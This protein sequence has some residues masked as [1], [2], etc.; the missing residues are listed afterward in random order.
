MPP[1]EMLWNLFLNGWATLRGK[2]REGH[3]PPNSIL[4]FWDTEVHRCEALWH[5]EECKKWFEESPLYKRMYYAFT[6]AMERSWRK[7][8]W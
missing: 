7:V 6:D 1:G 4:R 3:C 5:C 8:Q 2:C